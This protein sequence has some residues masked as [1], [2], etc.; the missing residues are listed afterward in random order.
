MTEDTQAVHEHILTLLEA[1]GATSVLDLGCGPGEHLRMLARTMPAGVRLAGVDFRDQVLA[2]ARASVGDDPRLAFLRHDLT[3]RLPFDDQTFDRVLSVNVLEAIPDKAAFVREA[4]RVLK[5]G[6]RVVCA[7]YEWESQLFDGTDKELVRRI[8]NAYS[9]WKLSWM[10]TSDGWMG[11]RLWGVFQ[12]SGLFE[13]RM[14]AYTHTS[15]RYEAGCYGFDRSRDFEGL[16]KRGKISQDEYDGFV[17]GL[18]RL[19]EQ[20]RYFFAITMFSYV[21]SKN[22]P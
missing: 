14:D 16:V 18:D 1:E 21:G 20:E 5:P 6:G 17:G 9:E 4:H 10:P 11:R 12:E 2:E 3:E 13:G 22:R 7:H 8:V 15:T 19:A